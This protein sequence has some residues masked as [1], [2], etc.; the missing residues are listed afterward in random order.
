MN[1]SQQIMVR[2]CVGVGVV[3]VVGKCTKLQIDTQQPR[4]SQLLQKH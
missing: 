3:A 1:V 2:F 4:R